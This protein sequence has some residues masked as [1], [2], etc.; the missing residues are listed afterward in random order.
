[1]RQINTTKKW[2]H[3]ETSR[4]TLIRRRTH[5]PASGKGLYGKSFTLNP[6]LLDKTNKDVPLTNREMC[7]VT[8]V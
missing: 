3:L 8:L 2:V 7:Q 1:M 5:A 4:G 6:M